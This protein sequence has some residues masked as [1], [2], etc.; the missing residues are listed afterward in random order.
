MPNITQVTA[1]ASEASCLPSLGLRFPPRAGGVAAYFSRGRETG[2]P[3]ASLGCWEARMPG[4][5]KECSG[6]GQWF[7][8]GVL[9]TPLSSRISPSMLFCLL[10]PPRGP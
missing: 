4:Q 10:Q 7:S 1:L 6:S 5:M 2:A 8:N 3:L 9:S